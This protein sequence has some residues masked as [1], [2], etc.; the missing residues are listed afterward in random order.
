MIPTF[1]SG[2]TLC[3]CRVPCETFRAAD[4]ESSLFSLADPDAFTKSKRRLLVPEERPKLGREKF[5]RLSVS[6][7]ADLLLLSSEATNHHQTPRSARSRSGELLLTASRSTMEAQA[8][9]HTPPRPSVTVSKRLSLR[10][11]TLKAAAQQPCPFHFEKAFCD[12]RLASQP[13]TFALRL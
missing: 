1:V 9:L 13:I 7:L 3:C 4:A 8:E 12:V 11:S 2:M 10:H 5:A 6:D